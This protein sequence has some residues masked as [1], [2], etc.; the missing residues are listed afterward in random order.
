MEKITCGKVAITKITV[1]TDAPKPV[2]FAAKELRA[3]LKK[4][5][6]IN[7]PIREG[8]PE[9]GNFFITTAQLSPRA[10]KK[11]GGFEKRTFDR[12]LV[13][14]QGGCVWLIGE[15]PRSALYAVYDFLQKKLGARFF[16]PGEEHEIVPSH[17]RLHLELGFRDRFGSAFEIRDYYALGSPPKAEVVDF[18]AKNRINTVILIWWAEQYFF[19]KKPEMITE[20]GLNLRGPGHIW[21]EFLPDA[22][23]MEAHPEYFP[24]IDGARTVTGKGACF[25]N[26]KVREIFKDKVRKFIRKYPVWDIFALWAEDSD[27]A[28]YCGCESCAEKSAGEWYMILINE[29]A[30]VVEKELPGALFEFIAYHET[31]WPAKDFIPLYKNGRNMLLDLCLGYTRDLFHPLSERTGGSA[32][33]MDMYNAWK[34]YLKKANFK[35]KRILYEYYNW[36]EAPNMGP[37]GRALL[38]PMEVIRKDTLYYKKEKL[39]GLGDFI[40][41]D[42]LCWPTPLNTWCWLHLYT[43]PKRK[44]DDFKKDFYTSYFGSLANVAWAYMD[45]LEE[46]MNERTSFKNITRVEKLREQLDAMQVH[47]EDCDLLKRVEL[48]KIHHEWCVLHKRIWLAFMKGDEVAYR[49]LEKPY[50]D[51]MDVTHQAA[52]EGQMDI[53]AAWQYQYYDYIVPKGNN[54]VKAIASDPTRR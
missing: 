6:G 54:Y 34:K 52:L 28:Y 29:V 17:E 25:S 39:N 22:K 51:F 26:P 2:R 23:L 32:E 47:A 30:P 20:R 33:V 14:E 44:I 24:F 38:W 37:A 49:A 7:F 16:A 12:A 40:V 41:F 1:P 13:F 11:A 27:Y 50:R 42:R 53:P 21:R 18:L 9:R 10:L 31:R 45:A 8:K 5:L 35:G 3:Y 36:C 46:A 43:T 4:G 15:N 48:L 19:K